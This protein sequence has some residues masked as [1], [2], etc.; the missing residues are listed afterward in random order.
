MLDDNIVVKTTSAI[1]NVV[2][3]KLVKFSCVAT[4]AI[5]T[6]DKVANFDDELL[7]KFNMK[8]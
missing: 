3:N 4:F 6:S 8:I 7:H 1:Q 5:V 2:Y